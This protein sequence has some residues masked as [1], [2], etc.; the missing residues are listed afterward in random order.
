VVSKGPE[1]VEIP[2]DGVI[3][4]GVDDATQTLEDL[5]LVVDVEKDP[6]YLGLGYVLRTDPSPGTSVP[7]GSTV[8]IYLI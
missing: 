6:T 8:I 7:K 3:A 1:M 2:R 5:G 4:A